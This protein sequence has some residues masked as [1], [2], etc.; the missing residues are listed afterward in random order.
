MAQRILLNLG[1]G[2]W[3]TGFASVTAQLWENELPPIQ[4]VGS[5]PPCPHLATQYQRWQQLYEAIYGSQSR[6]RRAPSP[7]EFES[8]TVTNVSHHEFETLCTSLHSELN[9]WLMATTFAPIERRLRTHLSA[10]AAIQVMLT[11][12][13]KSVLRFPWGLWQLFEDYPKA[14]LS[15]SLP[16]YHRALKQTQGNPTGGV[17]ILAVLGNDT[18][19][20]VETDRQILSQLPQAQVTLLAQP[21]LSELQHQLWEF[22]WDILFFAGHSTSQGQGYLQV[23]QTESLSI[24]QL[25]YALGRTIQNGLQL[26]I[27]NSCDGLGLA[28]T[29]A[30]LH[31]PQTI[32]M[33]EPVPDAIAHQFLKGFLASFASGQPLYNAVREARE[34]LHGLS[35]LGICAAWLPVIVQNPAEVPPTWSQLASQPVEV[36]TPMMLPQPKPARRRLGLGSLAVTVTIL[37]LRWAGI[38]Q[39][40]E[41]WT[42]DTLM[43]LRPT[44]TP[45]SRL[46]VVTVDENDIQSQTS[47]D[48]R[49]S[50]ADEILHQALTILAEGEPRTIGLDLYRDFPARDPA[51]MAA[52]GQPNLV[53]LC[54]SR[55]VTAGSVGISPPP[56]LPNSQVG[57]SDFIEEPDGL[58]RR[59]LL[60]LTPDPV[61]PCTS[62]YGFAT[63]VAIHYLQAEGVQPRFTAQGDLQIGNVVFPRLNQRT[64][65]LQR[66]DNGGNQ[67][68]L[69]Y[70]ALSTP[71]QIAVTISL[72]E[73]LGGQVNLERLRDR[74]VLI[75]ITAPSGGDYW[76][77]PYG[78][79]GQTRTAGVFMQ[80]QMISQLISAVEDGR[81]LIWVWPQW[82]ETLCIALG[83][84][85]GSLLAWQWKSAKLAL[86]CVVTAIA[87]IAIAWVTLLT[88]G[89][90]P[91]LPTLLA[92]NGSAW[93]T[94]TLE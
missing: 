2:D 46:V 45:D 42:Y 8:T 93:V 34:K 52:L 62:P 49:G 70:R 7:F 75:G 9:Q 58:V 20:D 89:W 43:R 84:I 73:L 31:L 90:L 91:L 66:M 1:Q 59:Q 6:W 80:A 56:E 54:K 32:V 10:Q 44:E 85:A 11:A 87:L 25:K 13:A 83:V 36:P 76:S 5:L 38:L 72:Q 88:G 12:Q 23:N 61:S 40:I 74:I 53:G 21:S 94:R 18:D 51:L 28:W 81:P 47:S 67:L 55:D 33:R 60:T 71:K 27:L 39:P 68:L 69:N 63:L 77:T 82:A 78:A 29:L 57:F 26:A 65:G 22:C 30:D 86:A 3:H 4:F 16:D 17:S 19:I 35:E 79:Q 14:E 15:L 64:G 37:A 50:V 41:L 48:R 24:E 92:L